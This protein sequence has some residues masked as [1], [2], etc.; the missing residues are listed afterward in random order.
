MTFITSLIYLHSNNIFP[1]EHII[2]T[3]ENTKYKRT[4]CK[5]GHASSGEEIVFDTAA[6]SPP[7]RLKYISV[8]FNVNWKAFFRHFRDFRFAS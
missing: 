7:Y 3:S 6:F 4:Y 2:T 8:D 5:P 1:D